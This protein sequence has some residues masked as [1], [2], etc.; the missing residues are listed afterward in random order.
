MDISVDTSVL[1]VI[2]PYSIRYSHTPNDSS[3][4]HM[5]LPYDTPILQMILPYSKWYF[6]T[7]CDT[8]VL[9]NILHIGLQHT[10]FS[11]NG[12]NSTP[13]LQ[14]YQTLHYKSGVGRFP[15]DKMSP[16]FGPSKK[17]P[18]HFV[19]WKMSFEVKCPWEKCPLEIV[20]R[21]KKSF[22]H[23]LKDF[24]KNVENLDD[25]IIQIYICGD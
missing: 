23:E 5:I 19:L 18:L 22:I 3:V 13:S 14:V 16:T 12:L 17:S 6:H 21:V 4:L 24:K 7:S 25:A 8:L 15:L 2:L 1:Q 9:H 10:E 20:P 11:L